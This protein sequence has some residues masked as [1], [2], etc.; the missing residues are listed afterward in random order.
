M[1][2]VAGIHRMT[3][4]K[5]ILD[6]SIS[7]T[8]E[9]HSSVHAQRVCADSLLHHKLAVYIIFKMQISSLLL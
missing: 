1:K 3:I 7:Y 8:L 5:E 6:N 4:N 9:P 2:V